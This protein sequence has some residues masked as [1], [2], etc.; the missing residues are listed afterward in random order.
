MTEYMI[1]L[2]ICVLILFIVHTVLLIDL[3]AQ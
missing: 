2:L 3:V 1:L